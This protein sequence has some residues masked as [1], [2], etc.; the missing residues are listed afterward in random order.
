MKFKF[1]RKRKFWVRC[2]LFL[3]L[4]PSFLFSTLVTLLYYKQDVVVQELIATLNEDFVGHFQINGSHISPFKNFPYISIDLEELSIFEN[5]N[6]KENHLLDIHDVYVGFNIWDIISGD[7]EIKSIVLNN[8]SINIVQHPDGSF[9]ITDALE[10]KKKID[11]P[12]EE[13][14]INL[15]SIA[16]NNIDINKLNQAN[17]MYFDL[18]IN[19]AKSKFKS[20]GDDLQAFL[21]AKFIITYIDNGDTSFIH[22]KH[23]DVHTEIDYIAKE[24]ILKIVPSEIALEGAVFNMEGDIDFAD[25]MNLNINFKGEKPNFDLL[26]AFAPDELTPTLELYNNRGKVF[27]NGS[28]LGPCING[29]TPYIDA[30]FGCSEAFIENTANDKKLDNLRFNGHFSNGNKRDITTME[31][32]LSDFSANPEAGVFSGDLSVQNFLEPDINLKLV[33]DFKLDFLAKFFNLE[34]LQ[35][36][37]GGVELTM[38]FHDIIDLNHPEKSIEK[39]N[40]SYFTELKVT[41]LSF[42]T[43][44]FHLPLKDLDLYAVM[45]G[46]KASIDYFNLLIGDSDLQ[47]KGSVDDLPAIL[48]HTAKDVITH[49]E[50]SSNF[51]DIQQLTS[52]SKDTLDGIN[53]S[54]SEMNLALTFKSSA[55]DFTESP[56]LPIGEFFIDDFHAQL[57]NYPHN[58]HDFHADLIIEEENLKLIDFSGMIDKSD[59]HFDGHLTHY[60]KWFQQNPKGDAKVEFNLTSNILQ[61]EDLFSYEGENYVPEDYRHEEFDDLKIHGFADLHFNKTLYSSD[62]TFDLLEAK[63]KVHHL[64]FKDF[65]GRIHL[66]DD[67]LLVENFRGKLGESNFIVNAELFLGG[68][69]LLKN[70][71]NY[72]SLKASKLDF[73]QLTAYQQPASEYASSPQDHEKGFNIYEVPFPNLKVDVDIKDLNYHLYKIQNFEGS[74]RIKPTH[75]VY[76]DTLSLDL[77]GG[78]MRMSGY[79]N[80]SNPKLIYF[81]PKMKLTNVNLD[82]LLVKFENFGQDY[83]VSENLHGQL[84]GDLWGKIHL[85]KDMVPIIDDSEIHLDFNVLSGKL[86]NFGPMEYLAE[87]FADKNVAK[88]LFDT[89]QNHIDLK[90]GVMNI[91]NMKINTSLGF[92]EISGIQNSD[93][94]YE[95]Y[96]KVPWKMITKAGASK[97]FGKKTED[98]DPDQEDQIIYATE[99][100]KIRYVN[101]L[102]K[103]DLE[104]YTIKLKKPN[105]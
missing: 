19:S 81:S 65:G 9:N 95:Y 24:E 68:D 31:F 105:S 75:F 45:D 30:V 73:D 94:S 77:A 34:Y 35:D 90:D 85:H 22:D 29:H 61:L 64:R 7:M 59:F 92:V 23:F 66:E 4:L 55:R 48:H 28:V 20:A 101:I 71:D 12:A 47:I 67:N 15:K 1:L 37:S 3:V 104:D 54:L 52:S 49:L 93:Y 5:E 42:K 46:H 80:G 13:F 8:G 70:K 26:I 83:L 10:T 51:L 39:L 96:L 86:E 14:H 38:N 72:V 40:E 44:D 74:I 17:G 60:D 76:V 33:S 84:S 56:Y 43:P 11:D 99:G 25:N 62:V 32:S 69:T 63:M 2:I 87:Y 50:I 102:V 36:L 6:K 89:L 21:D 18:Y 27:F 88:V 16:L 100:K 97:L 91:P 41:D 79:F 98:V 103:G 53:E 78:N 58:F 57:K 82:Q